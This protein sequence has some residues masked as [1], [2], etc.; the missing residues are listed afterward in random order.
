MANK[1]F[2]GLLILFVLIVVLSLILHLVYNKPREKF[3][4]GG[5]GGGRGTGSASYQ[6]SYNGIDPDNYSEG[7]KNKMKNMNQDIDPCY[8]GPRRTAGNSYFDYPYSGY[9]NYQDK[10][11]RFRGCLNLCMENEGTTEEVYNQCVNVCKD[12]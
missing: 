8:K 11:S 7:F 5:H 6:N 12:V 9:W 1:L 10:E 2:T 3:G 4:G